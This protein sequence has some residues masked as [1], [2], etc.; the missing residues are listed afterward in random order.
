MVDSVEK[1]LL[2]KCP[3]CKY[4]LRG[5]PVKHRCPEC[6]QEFDRLWK[7]FGNTPRWQTYGRTTRV[8]IIVLIL[9]VIFVS[10]DTTTYLIR[11]GTSLSTLTTYFDFKYLF[12]ATFPI[13]ACIFSFRYV[14][15]M[16]P[17]FIAVGPDGITVGNRKNKTRDNY[18]WQDVEQ[19]YL[20]VRD[21]L[22]LNIN[23][24]EVM[25]TNWRSTYSEAD[26]CVEYINS[27][28]DDRQTSTGSGFKSNRECE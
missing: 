25:I 21:K 2:E 24:V 23:D 17:V 15:L 9:I 13:I 6:G 14:F 8:G 7:V 11:T 20:N 10:I 26:S 4:Q 16:P 3:F 19:A 22:I 18:P 27:W 1:Y 5:L 12:M 28:I